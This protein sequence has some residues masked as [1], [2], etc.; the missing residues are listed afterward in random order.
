MGFCSDCAAAK[1]IFSSMYNIKYRYTYKQKILVSTNQTLL[2]SLY[3]AYLM[4]SVAWCYD[5]DV[6]VSTHPRRGTF[7]S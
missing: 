3:A 5:D 4:M 2:S 1:R 6:Y 7:K